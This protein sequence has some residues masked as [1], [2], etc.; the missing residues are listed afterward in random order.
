VRGL[1]VIATFFAVLAVGCGSGEEATPP[2]PT[3]TATE[4]AP[5]EESSSRP[6]APTIEGRTLDGE[7]V[8]LAD[9]RGRAVLVNVWSSW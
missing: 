3:T 9:F 1:A 5:P 7:A 6:P 2:P 8:S 4:T